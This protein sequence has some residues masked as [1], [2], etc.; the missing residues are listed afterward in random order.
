[1]QQNKLFV[2]LGGLLHDVG[3]PVYRAGNKKN[4]SDAGADFLRSTG[5][6][7]PAVTEQVLYHH[8]DNIKEINEGLRSD[9]L[10][11]ITYIADNIASGADRRE[12]DLQEGENNQC[13]KKYMPLQS[14]FNILNGNRQNFSYR[15]KNAA[16]NEINYPVDEKIKIELSAGNYQEICDKLKNALRN[17]IKSSE[18]YINSLLE[19]LEAYWSFVPSS[20]DVRE[21][22]DISLFD[23]VKIT[24]A[25]GA[26]IYD[27]LQEQTVSD[28]R[29]ELYGGTSKFYNK[30]VF[31]MYSFDISGI[32]DFIYSISSV[33]SGSG[34]TLKLLRARSFYLE[35]LCEHYIDTLL[36]ALELTRANLI[37]SGGGHAYIL[38]PNTEYAKTTVNKLHRELNSWFMDNFKTSLYIA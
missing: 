23:H 29:K 13:F 24:A 25:V 21:L 11:Y 15:M 1:M 4:H 26:C 18:E 8:R 20:T 12:K 28:Y 9:S 31:L 32:Q 17:N 37:Y 38:L 16:D 33:S 36:A 22:P 34:G 10:A 3:K 35:M 7:I 2:I 6:D 14:V 30:K 27:Y 5:W 19:L